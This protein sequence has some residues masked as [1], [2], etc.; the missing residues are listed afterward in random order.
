MQQSPVDVNDGDKLFFYR[1]PDEST[2]K[3]AYLV[4]GERVYILNF[5]NGFGYTE[6]INPKG[7]TTK[8]WLLL[9][10]LTSYDR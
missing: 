3:S 1:L 5:E 6:F 4:K 2:K 8:G 7:V 10:Y 9:D